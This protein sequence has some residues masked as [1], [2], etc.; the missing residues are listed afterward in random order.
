M[1]AYSITI[2]WLDIRRVLVVRQNISCNYIKFHLKNKISNVALAEANVHVNNAL[3]EA[4]SYHSYWCIKSR[5]LE[6][7]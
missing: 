4:K 7:L 2:N 1:R 6:S 3:V 5:R